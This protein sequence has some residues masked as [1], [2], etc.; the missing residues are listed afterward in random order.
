MWVA[1]FQGKAR[2]AGRWIAY[3]S[4]PAARNVG[5]GDLDFYVFTFVAGQLVFQVVT[6]RW[7]RLH[8]SWQRLPLL[9]SDPIWDDSVT[10]FWPSD[11]FPVS[12]PPLHYLDD[13]G[14]NAFTNRFASRIHA[15]F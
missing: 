8:K 12:W 1:A 6:P 14:L 13:G 15:S 3:Y 10:Q 7:R 5:Q 11:G 4:E 2:F 9:T